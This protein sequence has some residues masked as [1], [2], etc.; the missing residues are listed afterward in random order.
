MRREVYPSGGERVKERWYRLPPSGTALRAGAAASPRCPAGSVGLGGS[1][2]LVDDAAENLFQFAAVELDQCGPRAS[3]ICC[4][5]GCP[6]PMW[7][8]A[9]RVPKLGRV[10]DPALRLAA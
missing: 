2:V 8:S 6:R 3:P 9:V 10:W 5:A 7:W 1:A 4:G